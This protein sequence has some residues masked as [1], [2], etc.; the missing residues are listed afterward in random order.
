MVLCKHNK[1]VHEEKL[2]SDG[3]EKQKKQ[4]EEIPP[5]IMIKLYLVGTIHYLEREADKLQLVC[6]SVG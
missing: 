3:K 1:D 2:P 4:G 6:I 5:T